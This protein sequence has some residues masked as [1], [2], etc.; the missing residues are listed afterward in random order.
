MFKVVEGTHRRTLQGI[1]QGV[2][3]GEL[4][5]NKALDNIDPVGYSPLTP[6]WSEPARD[7]SGSVDEEAG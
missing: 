3:L 6:C 4:A 7:S 1:A 2:M 5:V